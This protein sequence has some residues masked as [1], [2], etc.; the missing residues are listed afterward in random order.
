MTDADAALSPD[1]AREVGAVLEAIVGVSRALARPRTTPF[2]DAALTRTQVDILFVLAHAAAPVA[3][4]SLAATL[5]MTPGAITQ[6]VDQLQD[7]GLVERVVS[8]HDKRARVLKLTARARAQ[9]EAFEAATVTRVA[10]WFDS[11]ADDELTKLGAL[12][13]R[14]EAR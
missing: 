4:G 13:A 2:G 11:L 8:E 6:T 10:P 14:V 9:V 7:L 3:P 12:L 1:R 5:R